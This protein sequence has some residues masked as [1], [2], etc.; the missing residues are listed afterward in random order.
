MTLNILGPVRRVRLLAG[1]VTLAAAFAG[2]AEVAAAQAPALEGCLVTKQNALCSDPTGDG[3]LDWTT[4]RNVA[5]SSEEAYFQ[6]HG[7]GPWTIE[8]PDNTI[9]CPAKVLCQRFIPEILVPQYSQIL[10]RQTGN[11]TVFAGA[12]STGPED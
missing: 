10:V 4:H 3:D 11:G 2:V 12:L 8:Y 1:V 7:T 5:Y 6:Y 9:T